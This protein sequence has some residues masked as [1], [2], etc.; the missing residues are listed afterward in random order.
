MG[1][2]SL[3][4]LAAA[5]LL[6]FPGIRAAAQDSTMFRKHPPKERI[7]DK[8]FTGGNVGAQFGT[9]TFAEISP[10]IGYKIT[11]KIAAGVGVTYQYY[12]YK[13][14]YFDLETNVYGARVFGRYLFNSYLFGYAEEEYLNL[15]AFDFQR[16]RVDVDSFLAGGGYMQPI[17]QNSAAVIMILYNFTPSVYTPY[18]NP[19][20][21]IG[22]NI[23]F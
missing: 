6:V 10:L 3:F 4:K 21:R 16:R 20:I 8:I 15:E 13:D 7:L 19:I 2:K 12:H 18:S 14:Q 9:I 1:S 5:V 17:G 23:G 22:F 11:D